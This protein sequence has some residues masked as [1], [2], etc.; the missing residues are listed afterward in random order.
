MKL[1][2]IDTQ[3]PTLETVIITKIYHKYKFESVM[4]ITK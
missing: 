2:K 1:F 4:L 3:I